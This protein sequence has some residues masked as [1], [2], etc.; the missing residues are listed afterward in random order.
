H[1]DKNR[2]AP[3]GKSSCVQFFFFIEENRFFELGYKES[4]NAYR[5]SKIETLIKQLMQDGYIQFRDIEG[6]KHESMMDK[7]LNQNATDGS[8]GD[9]RP[10]IRLRR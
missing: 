4:T 5:F 1:L 8:G 3:E 10:K 7:A 2:D 9:L 6:A